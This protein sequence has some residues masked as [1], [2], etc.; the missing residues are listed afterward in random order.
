MADS[1]AIQCLKPELIQT[2]ETN[3]L[4][5]NYCVCGGNTGCYSWHGDQTPAWNQ[6]CLPFPNGVIVD[7]P[8]KELAGR[9]PPSPTGLPQSTPSAMT[10]WLQPAPLYDDPD[11]PGFLKCGA[12]SASRKAS[13]M[14]AGL[15]TVAS[16]AVFLVHLTYGV[17]SAAYHLE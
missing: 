16:V 2:H 17:S 9:D 14:Y 4:C 1:N 5:D 15:L 11:C 6:I 13:I 12:A 7:P 8:K 3:D 10:A